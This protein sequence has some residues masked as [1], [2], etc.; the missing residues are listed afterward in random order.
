MQGT[1]RRSPITVR[2][3][4]SGVAVERIFPYESPQRGQRHRGQARPHPPGQA[5]LPAPQARPQGTH[6]RGPALVA[7]WPA[8]GRARGLRPECSRQGALRVAGVDEAGRGCW[9]GPVV[10]AAVILPR[11]GARRTRRLEAPELAADR[12]RIHAEIRACLAGPPAAV[13]ARQIDA[14]NVLA[15][16]LRGHGP[17]GRCDGCGPSPTWCWST[18]CRP[19]TWACACTAARQGRRH[20]RGG[21]GR[22]GPGQGAA[23]PRDGG[24][25]PALA[26]VTASPPTRATARSSTG[27]PWNARPQ[28]VASPHLPP[29]RPAGPGSALER[30][31]LIA[32]LPPSS[33]KSRCHARR[34]PRTAG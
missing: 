31:L 21:R 18:A 19:P 2:K 17:R 20:Q 9:A 29:G 8:A 12:E 13:A 22:V 14:T 3:L 26:G 7:P 5:V 32:P 1:G 16:T 24:L 27:P 33:R 25:G 15:A 30:V 28:S 10:A 11:L 34:C 6:P 4:T 23:R